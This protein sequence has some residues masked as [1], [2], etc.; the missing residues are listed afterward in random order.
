MQD[1]KELAIV[2]GEYKQKYLFH[3]SLIYAL[4]FVLCV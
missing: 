4:V 2:L 3:V 1:V